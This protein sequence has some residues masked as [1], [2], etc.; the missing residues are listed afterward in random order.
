[1]QQME[2]DKAELEEKFRN[3]NKKNDYSQQEQS[4]SLGIVNF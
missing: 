4:V 2:R 1:M 3:C